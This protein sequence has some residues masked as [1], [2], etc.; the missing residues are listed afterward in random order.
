[1]DTDS[2]FHPTTPPSAVHPMTSFDA[3]QR[4]VMTFRV[5]ELVM[6]LGYAGRNKTG[7]KQELQARALDLAKSRV[8]SVVNK[9]RELYKTIQ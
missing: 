7:R 4:M 6:L 3:F 8:T 2:P 5:S 1:M 9:I